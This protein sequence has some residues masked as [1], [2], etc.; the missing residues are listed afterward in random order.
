[1]SVPVWYPIT[2]SALQGPVLGP[3]RL[4]ASAMKPSI[5]PW[6]MSLALAVLVCG[7]P[8]LLSLCI[9]N[10]F[11]QS[12]AIGSGTHA[13]GTPPFIGMPAAPG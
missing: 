5:F 2:S 10:G 11:T 9:T 1:M 3:Q 7:P 12:P 8:W 13:A 6:S 4:S